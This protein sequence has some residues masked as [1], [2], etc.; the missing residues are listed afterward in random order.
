LDERASRRAELQAALVCA[1][2]EQSFE[3]YYQPQIDTRSMDVI[4]FEA[5]VRWRR[6]GTTLLSP[7]EFIP[8]AEETGLI[9]PM[10]RWVLLKACADCAQW[11]APLF[12]AVN[13]SAVQFASRT[14]FETVETALTESNLDPTRLELEITESSL[15]EDSVHARETLAALRAKGLRIALDDFGT[16]YSSLAYLRNFPIDRLKIDGAFTAG[17]LDDVQGEASAIVRAIVQLATALKLRTT[18]EGVETKVQLDALRAR[19][20]FESQG[21]YFAHPMPGPEVPAFLESWEK[22]RTVMRKQ[23]LAVS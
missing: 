16:G 11:P 1:V 9:I 19:G 17:L 20:C 6:N 22:E 4:G 5:L 14:L 12:V 10:G 7:L 2:N 3:V 8:L 23:L 15:V 18:A 13:F 21:F